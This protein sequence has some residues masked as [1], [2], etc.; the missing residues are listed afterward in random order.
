M[1][2]PTFP[3]LPLSRGV[4]PCIQHAL[5][6]LHII[7]AV[8]HVYGDEPSHATPQS[9]EHFV[10]AS[11]HVYGDEPSPA[12]PQSTEQF[13]VASENLPG[14]TEHWAAIS[15]EQVMGSES[16]NAGLTPLNIGGE[17]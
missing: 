15:S 11:D 6:P 10:V 5:N 3:L 8:D 1:P 14:S 12:T 2:P 17:Q 9:T 16:G 7:A 13:V 4:I